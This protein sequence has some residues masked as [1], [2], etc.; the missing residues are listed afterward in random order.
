MALEGC[1]IIILLT[2]SFVPGIHIFMRVLFVMVSLLLAWENI[3]ILGKLISPVQTI[4][5]K[6]GSLS[7]NLTNI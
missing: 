7:C 5:N 6:N 2:N 1:E 4:R 3:L